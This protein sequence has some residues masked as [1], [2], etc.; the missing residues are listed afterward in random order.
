MSGRQAERIKLRLAGSEKFGLRRN[1]PVQKR[2]TTRVSNEIADNFALLSINCFAK[3]ERF[4]F[5]R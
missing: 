3:F 5:I 2:K 4:S 1:I